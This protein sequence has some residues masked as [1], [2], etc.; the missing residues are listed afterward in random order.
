MK[1]VLIATLLGVASIMISLPV[2]NALTPRSDFS[3]NVST[4]RLFDSTKI[5]GEHL[6]KPGEWNK[7]INN[8]FSS[9]IKKFS[10]LIGM[11]NPS[12]NTVKNTSYD[13]KN[14][15][16]SSG[17]I[18]RINTFGMDGGRFTSF[19]SVTNK[20]PFDV[21][22]IAISQINPDVKVLKAWITPQWDSSIALYQ[23]SF[24]TSKT[25][26]TQG[27]TLNIVIV[28]D[29][30]P[31]F[32]LDTLFQLDGTK[33]NLTVAYHHFIEKNNNSINTIPSHFPTC[34]VWKCLC[35]F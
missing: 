13:T 26:L 31:A 22:H 23:T 16:I 29:G 5:C 14:V 30:K 8:L 2:A 20:G 1:P 17:D 27:Q 33:V 4:Y 6:C 28:T 34:H 24:D 15:H 18:V 7:W 3:D 12:S 32:S 25:S 35:R 9:Q 21:N 10:D 19:I 11:K